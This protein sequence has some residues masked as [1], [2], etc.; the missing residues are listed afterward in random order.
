M[1]MIYTLLSTEGR[2]GRRQFWMGMLALLAASLLILFLTV[3]LINLQVKSMALIASCMV[4]FVYSNYCL[5]VKRLH[6]RGRNGKLFI[7]YLALHYIL[8]FVVPSEISDPNGIV[9]HGDNLLFWAV[10]FVK[11]ALFFLALYFLVIC[12]ALKGTDGPNQYGRD[13]LA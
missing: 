11:L 9:A 12:G 4:M 7:V 3:L 1:E 6:D 13:P 2:I 10:Q 5:F 8:V